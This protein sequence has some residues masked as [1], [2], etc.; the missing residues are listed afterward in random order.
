MQV[1]N[2][3]YWVTINSFERKSLR[4]LIW[5]NL[6]WQKRREWQKLDVFL[7]VQRL[8]WDF[9]RILC[10]IFANERWERNRQSHKDD[11]SLIH[12]HRAI[13]WVHDPQDSQP[14]RSQFALWRFVDIQHKLDH[15]VHVVLPF[16]VAIGVWS[17]KFRQ[18]VSSSSRERCWMVRHGTG[19]S[20]ACIENTNNLN[21]EV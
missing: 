4:M 7:K 21:S 2:A 16:R 8:H 3:D 12:V 6:V 11:F 19:K 9:E 17:W 13:P 15:W 5:M 18:D 20:V 10:E 14:N 1:S